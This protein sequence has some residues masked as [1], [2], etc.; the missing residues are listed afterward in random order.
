MDDSKVRFAQF[1][2]AVGWYD[3]LFSLCCRFPRELLTAF[4]SIDSIQSQPR[5]ALLRKLLRHEASE[6]IRNLIL[7][8]FSF[9]ENLLDLR[10]MVICMSVL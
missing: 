5:R 1:Q 7:T 9:V 3:D 6:L 10:A 2:E 8:D 4:V